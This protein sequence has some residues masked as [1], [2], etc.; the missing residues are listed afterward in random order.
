MK[1]H[2]LSLNYAKT[3]KRILIFFIVLA[4]M[5]AVA[6]P[7]SLS[8]QISDAAALRQQYA[9][10][11]QNAIASGETT[12]KDHH[13][14]DM[15]DVW[16]SQITPLNAVNYAIIGALGVLRVV[17]V[18]YYWFTV[19][20]WLYKSAVQENMNKSLWLYLGLIFNFLAVMA[21]CIVRDRPEKLKKA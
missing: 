10:E 17:L 18:L 8:R 13:H 7:L 15:E 11:K 14:D 9:L 4:V 16:K 2:V 19:A 3:F 21:F 6:I 20:A 1:D 12:D 5:S